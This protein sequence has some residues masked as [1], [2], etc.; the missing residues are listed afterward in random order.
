ML[1]LIYNHL[2]ARS[3]SYYIHIQ[4]EVTGNEINILE[5]IYAKDLIERSNEN[6]DILSLFKLSR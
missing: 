2:T 5:N 6:P 1:H 3:S 4:L